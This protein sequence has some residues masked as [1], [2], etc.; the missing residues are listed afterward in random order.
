MSGKTEATR[1][2]AARLMRLMQAA[3]TPQTAAALAG[4]L[5]LSGSRETQ[6]RHIRAL[7][8]RLRDDGAWIVAVDAAGYRLTTDAA[9]W[10]QYNESRKIGAKQILGRSHKRQQMVTDAAGQGLLFVPAVGAA[11]AKG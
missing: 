7:V 6:R 10:K 3:R 8:E 2:D 4:R 9:E 5:A 11:C 1:E